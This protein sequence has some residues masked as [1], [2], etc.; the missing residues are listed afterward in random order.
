[1]WYQNHK[2][3]PT[4]DGISVVVNINTQFEIVTVPRTTDLF[5][6]LFIGLIIFIFFPLEVISSHHH[7][8][9]L[10]SQVDN[11]T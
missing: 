7:N 4:N 10:S 3:E 1:M 2:F 5:T 8:V 6:A 9:D 11:E